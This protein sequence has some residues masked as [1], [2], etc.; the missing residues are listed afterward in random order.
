LP[1]QKGVGV[2]ELTP[3]KL[4]HF[5][6]I[7]SMH[8]QITNAVINRNDYFKREYHYIDANAGPGFY[9]YKNQ[10]LF[11]SPIVF[12]SKAEEF[13]LLYRADLIEIIQSN[14]MNLQSILPPSNFGKAEVHCCDASKFVK[15]LLRS[16]DPSQLGLIY[17]DPSTGIPDFDLA[18]FVAKVRPRMEILLYLSATNLKRQYGVSDQKLSDYIR[19]INKG[20]WLVRKP[21]SWDKHQWTFLLGSNSDLFRNY[22]KI[23]FYR[24]NSKE[25]QSFFP[26]LNLTSVQ[27]RD[28]VQPPLFDLDPNGES[29]DE[30][31]NG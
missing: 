23:E 17:L 19:M 27:R 20:R 5:G 29:R 4:E 13:R 22:K 1:I 30:G 8:M 6:A 2:S 21:V 16:I 12:I 31:N 9:S 25:A 24:M 18:S 7:I 10:D 14:A 26:K 11:G 28:K 15:N 3:I